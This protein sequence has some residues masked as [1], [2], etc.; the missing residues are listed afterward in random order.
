MQQKTFTQLAGPL[1]IKPGLCST[2][3]EMFRGR[4]QT[5]S[6]DLGLLESVLVS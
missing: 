2:L 6:L 4:K 5:E 1:T 3:K